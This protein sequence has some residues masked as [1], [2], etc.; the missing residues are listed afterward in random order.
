MNKKKFWIFEAISIICYIG[1]CF[2]SYKLSI[3]ADISKLLVLSSFV[4]LI[5]ASY[6]KKTAPI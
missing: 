6:F 1:F 2:F 3:A 4:T 5:I